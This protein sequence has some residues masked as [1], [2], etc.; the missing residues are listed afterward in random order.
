MFWVNRYDD[1][2]D[3]YDEI[4][5]KQDDLLHELSPGTVVTQLLIRDLYKPFNMITY[6]G[7]SGH[8]AL[9]SGGSIPRSGLLRLNVKDIVAIII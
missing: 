4:E 5:H 7:M 1:K 2:Y 3:M 8:I 6:E 9:F